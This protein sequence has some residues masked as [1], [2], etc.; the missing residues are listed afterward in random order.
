MATVSVQLYVQ[1]VACWLIFASGSLGPAP[2]D[3]GKVDTRSHAKL[4][5]VI[6]CVDHTFLFKGMLTILFTFECVCTKK[7]HMGFPGSIF[8]PILGRQ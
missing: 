8:R 2:G 3:F 7:K 1:L 6:M 4:H 5:N